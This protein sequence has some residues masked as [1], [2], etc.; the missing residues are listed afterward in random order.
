MATRIITPERQLENRREYLW[1]QEYALQAK[2]IPAREIMDLVRQMIRVA[3]FEQ[4]LAR[5]EIK[6]LEV[7]ECDRDCA[8]DGSVCDEWED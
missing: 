1:Q 5:G 4:Q 3:D 7:H 8:P 6:A 2:G